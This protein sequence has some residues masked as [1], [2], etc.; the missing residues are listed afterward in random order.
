MS[1]LY[2]HIN[3]KSFEKFQHVMHTRLLC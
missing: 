1:S 2:L 3:A